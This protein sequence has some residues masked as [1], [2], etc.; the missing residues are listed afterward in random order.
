M[1]LNFEIM[2]GVEFIADDIRDYI[3]STLKLKK[4]YEIPYKRTFRKIP[5]VI[6]A[7]R[8]LYH[9]SI[10]KQQKKE[11]EQFFWIWRKKAIGANYLMP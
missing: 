8:Y 11:S 2:K 9:K 4:N 10:G 6:S 3:T 7:N 1:G 5:F